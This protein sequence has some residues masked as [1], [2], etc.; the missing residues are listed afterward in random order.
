M[1][2][3]SRRILHQLGRGESIDDVRAAAGLTEAKFETWWNQELQRRLAVIDGRASGPVGAAVEIQRDAS[4]LPHIYAQNESD[5]FVGYGYAMAQDRLFQMD[6]LRRRALG[7]LSEILGPEAFDYDLLV[8]TVGLH[9]IAENETARLPAETAARY[10]AFAAGVN[11]F[12]DECRDLPPIEFDLLDYRPEPWRP[13]D[14]IALLGELRWYLTGRFPVIAVPELA[15]RALGDG[16]LYRAF[17]TPE[18]IDETILHPGEY[19]SAGS[20]TDPVEPPMGGIDDG[21]GSN[22]W[23]IGPSRSVSGGAMVASDPHIAFGAPCCW[24]QAHLVGGRFNVAGA[25]YA[26]APG[27]LFGRNLRV[28]WGITN[29]ISSQRDLYQERTDPAHPDAFLYDGNWEPARERVEAIG[30][31]GEG[32]R[33]EVV[34][35]S[36]NG[37]IVDRILPGFAQGTGP[38]S[39]C[40]AG[41]LLC[42]WPSSLLAL[43]VAESCAELEDALRGWGSPTLSMVFADVDGGFGYRATGQ[44]P[45]RARVERGYRR[46]WDSGDAWQGTIPFEGMPG[47]REPQRGWVATANNLPA[48]SDF[49]YPLAN[50][51]PTGYRARRIRQMLES[52]STHSREDMV[53]MQY[54][55]LALRALE[56]VPALVQ[57]LD[58]G[59]ARAK[60]AAAALSAWNRRM[61]SESTAA[62]IFEAFQHQWDQAVA[63]ERF[64]ADA[65]ALAVGDP[66]AFVAGG[67]SSLSLRL[68][69]DDNVGWFSSVEARDAAVRSVMARTLD[70]LAERLGDDMSTWSW[71]RLHT[72]QLPHLLSGR[73]D[74]GRLL[75][76]GGEPVSGNGFVVSNTGS[77]PDFNSSGGANY[78]LLVDLAEAPA[79]MWTL[80]AAGPSGQPGSP[81]Y[82]NQFGDWLSGRYHRIS[83]ERD[84][85]RPT[86]STTLTLRPRE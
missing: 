31:R 16:P 3:D 5:L 39:L 47:V 51:S 38:V 26:G 44:V 75:D 45:I 24:Y 84:A 79:Q 58:G 22:N 53:S 19:A 71:G 81:H 32:V 69:A 67:I 9:Q 36:R 80:D 76:R 10:E 66:A 65:S 86:I 27:I 52:R 57:V 48:P 60:A 70:Q 72:L 35:S 78:R 11:A 6:Y 17:I 73:G 74:L 43:N 68:L 59:N 41:A 46:G 34:R 29:N 56:A 20:G 4:G 1:A 8:R 12:I 15:R 85:V 37:P 25:G 82:A 21:T 14:S 23:V 55:V 50:M 64:S 7:R 49:P 42:A 83:L 2:I 54:D 77:A 61:D 30:V 18:A 62:A 33:E 63:A 40:W 28:A 13:L